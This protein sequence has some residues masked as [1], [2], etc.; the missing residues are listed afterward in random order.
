MLNG[1]PGAARDAEYFELRSKLLNRLAYY[2]RWRWYEH[3]RSLLCQ[4]D[5]RPTGCRAD[6]E[7]RQ[8]LPD[9]RFLE[10]AFSGADA[11]CPDTHD[12][13]DQQQHGAGLVAV[14]LD[15]FQSSGQHQHCELGELEQRA[16][17]DSGQRC[18][19]V[20][21]R[22]STHGQSFLPFVQTVTSLAVFGS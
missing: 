20:P 18:D 21:H 3:R 12:L 13:H 10:S 8:F 7:R 9:G 17:D 4:R 14:T 6:N 5:H 1:D 11:G 15:R 16:G 22:K 19:Q 2:R